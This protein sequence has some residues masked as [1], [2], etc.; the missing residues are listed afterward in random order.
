MECTAAARSSWIHIGRDRW[1]AIRLQPEAVVWWV[2]ASI[3]RLTF[4]KKS[5]S[6]G[7]SV[8][9]SDHGKSYC[10]WLN[11]W[12]LKRRARVQ[13]YGVYAEA[14]SASGWAVGVWPQL[15]VRVV[16]VAGGDEGT[17]RLR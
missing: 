5:D 7:L 12:P 6:S 4:V 15:A 1:N 14:F 17:V 9:D 10:P 8:A 13:D 16:Q 11:L 2:S 3:L